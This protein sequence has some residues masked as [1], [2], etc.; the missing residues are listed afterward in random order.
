MSEKFKVFNTKINLSH[1]KKADFSIK[2]K[3]ILPLSKEF[4][5]GLQCNLIWRLT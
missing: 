1:F 3:N 4:S 2:I 5:V